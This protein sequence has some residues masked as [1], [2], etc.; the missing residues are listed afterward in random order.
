MSTRFHFK[1]TVTTAKMKEIT[2]NEKFEYIMLCNKVCGVAHYNMKMPVR[3]L[4]KSE[5]E[6]WLKKDTKPAY[7]RAVAEAPVATADSLAKPVA[8]K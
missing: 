5:F 4:E 3:V 8:L 1:P 6:A 2:G 7:A